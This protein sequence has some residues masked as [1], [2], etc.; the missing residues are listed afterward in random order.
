MGMDGPFRSRSR[1]RRHARRD[2]GAEHEGDDREQDPHPLAHRSRGLHADETLAPPGQQLDD[3]RLDHRHQGHVAVGRHGD[4]AQ[5]VRGELAREEDR[6]GTV[7]A[8]VPPAGIA[9]DIDGGDG[10]INFGAA[11]T[12]TAARSI[13]VRIATCDAP[14]SVLRNTSTPRMKS[15]LS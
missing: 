7:G 9:V 6:G 10:A 4:G 11:I 8:A 1:R 13:E 2:A 12:N 15:R 5:Q 3:G 14:E